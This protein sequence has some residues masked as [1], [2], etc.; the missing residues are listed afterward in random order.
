MLKAL[1][2]ENCPLVVDASTTHLARLTS[3]Q[4]LVLRKTGF[5]KESITATGLARLASLSQLQHLNLS[6]TRVNDAAI[7][8]LT[9]LKKL[10]SLDLGLTGLGNAGLVHLAKL[11]RL[12]S[13]GVMYQEGFGGTKVT[14]EGLQ[15]LAEQPPGRRPDHVCVV[16][17]VRELELVRCFEPEL[18]CAAAL[19]WDVRVHLT[20]KKRAAERCP[21]TGAEAGQTGAQCPFG[22]EATAPETSETSSLIAEETSASLS[23]SGDGLQGHVHAG[24][25]DMPAI[26]AEVARHLQKRQ[27]KPSACAVLTCGPAAL[28]D[29][30]KEACVTAGGGEIRFEFHSETFDF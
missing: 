10:R 17:S 18:A 8:S 19:G 13:L 3:L 22:A 12:E 20:A 24:R 5:E 11:P 21:Q 23:E 26:F 30:T 7:A 6:A 14:A 27:R 1:N 4:G 25:P 16:W 15:H 2:L 9:N 29:S 28:V